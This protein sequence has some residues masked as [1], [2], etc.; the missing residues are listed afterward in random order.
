MLVLNMLRSGLVQQ[1]LRVD[2]PPPFPGLR[3]KFLAC[4]SSAALDQAAAR[5]ISRSKHRQLPT[6]DRD[7]GNTP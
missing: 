4:H 5:Q 1:A 6:A 2:R 7:L 3:S